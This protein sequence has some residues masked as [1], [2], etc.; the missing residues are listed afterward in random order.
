MFGLQNTCQKRERGSHDERDPCLFANVD[1]CHGPRLYVC[2][3][4]N[5]FHT[6]VTKCVYLVRNG[7][8]FA[9]LPLLASLARFL[10]RLNWLLL[11]KE[12]SCPVVDLFWIQ[13]GSR[14][15]QKCVMKNATR[16]HT[17][18]RIRGLT[19]VQARFT[20]LDRRPM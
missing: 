8:R 19:Y 15:D 6:C 9:R 20:R 17:K 10:N 5:A 1:M 16:S 12:Y 7:A 2:Q 11:S 14:M 3:A 18:K 4:P 13:N